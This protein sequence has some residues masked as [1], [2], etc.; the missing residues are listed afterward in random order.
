MQKLHKHASC[1]TYEQL[2]LQAVYN[3]FLCHQHCIK[4]P[5]RRYNTD[6][7]SVCISELLENSYN[8]YMAFSN[9]SI[10]LEKKQ[11]RV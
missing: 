3:G 4:N 2:L 8:L 7:Q 6:R 9:D 5:D 1:Q 11:T 10:V